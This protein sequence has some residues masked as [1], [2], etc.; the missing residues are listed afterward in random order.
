MSTSISLLNKGNIVTYKSSTNNNDSDRDSG[1]DSG[2]DS[3]G[4]NKNF[5][6]GYGAK[7]IRTQD[8]SDTLVNYGTRILYT[9]DL[10]LGNQLVFTSFYVKKLAPGLKPDATIC[11]EFI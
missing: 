5:N 6:G 2:G 7:I 4:I 1:G 8:K 3:D 10:R 11:I 9:L